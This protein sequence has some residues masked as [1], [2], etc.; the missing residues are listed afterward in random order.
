MS[1]TNASNASMAIL[2]TIN[3]VDGFDP[4]PLAVEYVDLT[5]QEKR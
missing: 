4:T 1:Q 2:N 5:T 3:K